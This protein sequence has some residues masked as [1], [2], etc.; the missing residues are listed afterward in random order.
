MDMNKLYYILIIIPIFLYACIDEYTH[1]GINEISEILVV[2]GMITDNVTTIKL[3]K[4]VGLNTDIKEVKAVSSAEVIVETSNGKYFTAMS[5]TSENGI[6]K[7]QVNELES[8]TE[9]RL[10]IK[11]EGKE[12]ESTFL[13]PLSTPAIDSIYFYKEGRGQPI[14]MTISTHSADNQETGYYLWSYDEIWEVRARLLATLTFVEEVDPAYK[15]VVIDASEYNGFFVYYNWEP[16]YNEGYRCW[17]YDQS[18]S[19]LLG[20]SDKLQEN[21]IV[22]YKLA[23]RKPDDNHFS[24]LYYVKMYQKSLR[25]EAYDYLSNMQK[26]SE[27]TGG[28]FGSVPSEMKGNITCVS[29]PSIDVIG[30]VE[31]T[32][33]T[34]MEK[35]ISSDIHF[36]EAPSIDCNVNSEVWGNGY[37]PYSMSLFGVE[38]AKERCIDCGLTEGNTKNKPLFWPN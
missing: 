38:F 10:R 25:K 33:T 7:I 21:R 29:N 24:W 26:N 18:N 37:L 9:Y 22:N 13:S 30:Y 16:Y 28:I 27:A 5:N 14:H 3:S 31:V 17:R 4:S 34:I 20:S 12:Y 23:E 35:F 2:E 19:L 32:T 8:N 6:Y 1:K 15:G 36:Y 11:A